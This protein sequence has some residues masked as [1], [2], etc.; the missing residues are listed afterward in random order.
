M[1]E[2]QLEPGSVG[3]MDLTVKKAG[4]VRDFYKNVVGWTTDSV[5]MGG[6]NDFVMIEPGRELPVAGICHA[7]GTNA[8]LPAQWLIYIT[9]ADLDASIASC[10]KLGG[11]VIRDAT[12]LTSDS[13]YCII[14]DPSGAVAALFEKK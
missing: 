8:G 10:K 5:D 3:W 6:Y 14:K 7:R 11:E 9:V 2:E 4:E 12:E 13:R 1:T